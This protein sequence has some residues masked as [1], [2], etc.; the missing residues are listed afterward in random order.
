MHDV[1]V[2]SC[3]GSVFLAFHL[4]QKLDDEPKSLE[5]VTAVGQCSVRKHKALFILLAVKVK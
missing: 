4:A 2:I 5:L 3:L 1:H